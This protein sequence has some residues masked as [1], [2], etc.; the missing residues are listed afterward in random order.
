MDAYS[1]IIFNIIYVH[2]L[3]ICV[4]A[5]VTICIFI[6]FSASGTT[7]DSKNQLLVLRCI[8]NMFAQP[9]CLSLVDLKRPMV[10]TVFVV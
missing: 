3:C 5:H 1:S 8:A 9:Q 4:H 6:Y 7:T 10:C 2:V